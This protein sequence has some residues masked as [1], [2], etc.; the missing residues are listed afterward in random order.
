ML[1]CVAAYTVALRGARADT[2]NA[3]LAAVAFATVLWAAAHVLL[4]GDRVER[5][6][7]GYGKPSGQLVVASA[8]RDTGVQPGAQIAVVGDAFWSFYARLARVRIIAQV[9]GA[10]S[11]STLGHEDG[12]RIVAKLRAAGAGAVI[13]NNPPAGLHAAG[14]RETV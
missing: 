13:A 14:W 8:L 2:R 6:L 11:F 10:N 12:L 9:L 7:A 1:F 5:D 3:A 4:A